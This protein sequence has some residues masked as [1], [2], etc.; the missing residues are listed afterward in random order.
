[1]VNCW[2]RFDPN[3]AFKIPRL[4]E[5]ILNLL[6][7]H[8]TTPSPQPR[9]QPSGIVVASRVR[10]SGLRYRILSDFSGE[11]DLIIPAEFFMLLRCEHSRTSQGD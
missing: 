7:G 3:A 9:R 8:H 6:T 11:T 1:M 5:T 10:L 4:S 2:P